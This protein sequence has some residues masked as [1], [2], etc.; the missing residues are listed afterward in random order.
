MITA[1]C[2]EGTERLEP[3]EERRFELDIPRWTR[4]REVASL[5]QVA[6]GFRSEVWI[7]KEGLRVNAKNILEMLPVFVGGHGPFAFVCTGVDAKH[8]EKSIRCTVKAWGPC[9]F[10]EP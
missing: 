4:V 9:R 2:T 7:L 5:V 6:S 8:C 1:G 10:E 3:Q